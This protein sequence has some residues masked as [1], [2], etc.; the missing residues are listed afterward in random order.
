MRMVPALAAV[1]E[2][3]QAERAQLRRALPKCPPL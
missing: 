3:T 1:L 2:L